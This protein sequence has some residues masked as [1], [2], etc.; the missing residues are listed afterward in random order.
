VRAQSIR[1]LGQVPKVNGEVEGGEANA[2]YHSASHC[3]FARLDAF[4][5]VIYR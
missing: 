4:L 5:E 2:A 3:G 1:Y